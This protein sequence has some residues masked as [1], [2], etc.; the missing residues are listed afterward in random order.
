MH[1]GGTLECVGAGSLLQLTCFCQFAVIILACS[2]CAGC[3]EQNGR[4]AAPNRQ[5]IWVTINGISLMLT[6]MLCIGCMLKSDS[7][8]DDDI[9]QALC[10]S[11]TSLLFLLRLVWT[12]SSSMNSSDDG[13]HIS[14]YS[15]IATDHRHCLCPCHSSHESNSLTAL[16]TSLGL[17]LETSA[18]V[19]CF[20]LTVPYHS[21]ASISTLYLLLLPLHWGWMRA[22]QTSWSEVRI[23]RWMR[24]WNVTWLSV[25][26]RQ[27]LAGVEWVA[28]CVTCIHLRSFLPWKCFEL[29]VVKKSTMTVL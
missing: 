7:W 29:S 2:A 6:G 23:S 28:S 26:E 27:H 21:F 22:Q 20:A 16:K 24:A 9:L 17:A 14:V 3:G 25:W 10:I 15:W 11:C 4:W 5:N 13:L 1:K 18:L 12:L 8:E 19:A